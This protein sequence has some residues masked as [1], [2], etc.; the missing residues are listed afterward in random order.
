MNGFRCVK[1]T[2]VPLPETLRQPVEN[3]QRDF[4]TE[5]PV[6][7]DVFRI[8]QSF[9]SYDRAELKANR[10]SVDEGSPYWKVERITFD[11]AYDHQ[12]LAVWLYVP[13]NAK[14]PYQTVIYAAAGHA[15]MVSSIDDKEISQFG[16][17]IKSGRAVLVPAF[18]GTF[19]RRLTAP[20]GPNGERDLLIQQQK[21]L[22][23]S[24]DYLE[25]RADVARDRLG[26]YGISSGS[27]IGLLGLSQEPRVRAAVLAEGG[28]G[29]HR[30]FPEVDAI[31]FVSRVRLPVLMLNGRNDFIF[32]VDTVQLP[33]F[34]LLGTPEA[35]KRYVQFDRGHANPS[36]LYIKEALDWFDRYL[37]APEK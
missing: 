27:Q 13:R 3:P 5:R 7:D 26:F 11:A 21:D 32:P 10:E 23:R 17:L 24:V 9:Y 14:P 33:M 34:H 36:Q 20:K 22:R 28:L 30:K 31:N 8:L 29:S 19:D 18:Q 25:T 6:S 16:F 35:D 15:R 4:R 12:R 2:S 37:G 1:Y